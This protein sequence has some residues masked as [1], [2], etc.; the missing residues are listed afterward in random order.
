MKRRKWVK[1]SF[2]LG[3]MLLVST[4]IILGLS[5]AASAKVVELSLNHWFPSGSW[6]DKVIKD[7]A[8]EIEKQT[9]GQVKITI[10]PGGILTKVDQV[11]DGVVK[12]ISDIG[13]APVNITLGR[14]PLM[15]VIDLPIG[16]SSSWQGS[17][18]ASEIYK[19][20]H[21][22]EF[23][24]T[25]PLYF[26]SSVPQH[27]HTQKQ[28]NKLE[29]LKG[30]KIRSVPTCANIVESLGA[31]PVTMPI[32]DVYTAL[33]RGTVD[34]LVTSLEPLKTFRL[35]EVIRSTT[36]CNLSVGVIYVTMNRD[37]WDSL[38]P[39][40]KKIFDEV[41]EKFADITSRVFDENDLVGKN[42]SLSLGNKVITLPPEELK[43][44]EE[45][46]QPILNKWVAENEAK[47][48]PAR[49]VLDEVFKLKEKYR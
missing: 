26:F 46:Y 19:K 2:V 48:L 27:F 43:R 29:D 24:E 35:A 28:I 7:F 23:A 4:L 25:R 17:H 3:S 41:S 42:F 16:L 20:F 22:K 38:S 47:G 6:F 49:A 45:H 32:T 40:V 11:Y 13:V 30:L 36:I 5:G 39:A 15:E 44:W 21:P 1:T 14:F 10:Y 9:S 31:I 37:K 33:Q 34:G 18:V 8:A 12:G